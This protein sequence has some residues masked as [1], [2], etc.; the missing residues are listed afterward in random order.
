M[1]AYEEPVVIIVDDD[2]SCASRLGLLLT[3]STGAAVQVF[4][5]V[6]DVE[7]WME[8]VTALDA[9]PPDLAVVDLR[10][11]DG[12]GWDVAQLVN[13]RSRDCPVIAWTAWSAGLSSPPKSVSDHVLAIVGKSEADEVLVQL[14]RSELSARGHKLPR[15]PAPPSRAALVERR[16]HRVAGALSDVK[17]LAGIALAAAAILAVLV[18]SWS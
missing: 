14:V 15:W 10:L 11:P 2:E 13:A 7:A 8:S 12:H 3:E 16:L 1:T 18:R 6:S 5:R 9:K 4:P 17:T